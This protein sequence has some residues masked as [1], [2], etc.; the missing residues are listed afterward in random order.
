METKGLISA[1]WRVKGKDSRGSSGAL[2]ADYSR[3]G[4]VNASFEVGLTLL[5]S[6]AKRALGACI[7]PERFFSATAAGQEE[8]L[9]EFGA[10]PYHSPDHEANNPFEQSVVTPAT[11]VVQ[12]PFESLD[13]VTPAIEKG[14][15]LDKPPKPPTKLSEAV[16]AEDIP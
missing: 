3:F 2:F 4:W 14:N 16:S 8:L 5:G 10:S 15:P 11:A 1:E 7:P 6:H 13:F 9:A 12:N